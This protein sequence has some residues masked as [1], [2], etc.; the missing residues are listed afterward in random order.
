MARKP[1]G[2]QREPARHSLAA[3]GINT[4]T[5]ASTSSAGTL[6]PLPELTK[7]QLG[8]NAIRDMFLS[9]QY[10]GKVPNE[11]I[12]VMLNSPRWHRL[13]G[14]RCLRRAWDNLVKDQFVFREGDQWLWESE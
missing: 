3:K 10:S 12:D 11:D 2:W 9:R 13:Y 6:T 4:P 8:E 1:I 7:V 5:A 14:K